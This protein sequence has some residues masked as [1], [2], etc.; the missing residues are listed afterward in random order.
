MRRLDRA[1]RLIGEGGSLAD[2]AIA[3]GFVDQSHMNRHFK[4]AFGMTPGRWA[5]LSRSAA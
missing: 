3:S 4:K 5:A 1:K 2:A